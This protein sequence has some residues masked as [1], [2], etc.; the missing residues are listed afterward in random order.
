MSS[1]PPETR[2][3]DRAWAGD[4]AS[5]GPIHALT[6]GGPQP[7]S[8]V[9]PR[10]IKPKEFLLFQTLIYRESGIWLSDV[11]TELLTGRLSKRLRALRLNTFS[12]Y[13]SRVR[14]DNEERMAMLDAI[15]T[16]D[17]KSV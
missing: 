8:D 3:H 5:H 11:K 13:Y 2:S 10:P 15:S 17:R 6:Q 16:K 14:E 4:K 7:T 12:E 1:R 9:A